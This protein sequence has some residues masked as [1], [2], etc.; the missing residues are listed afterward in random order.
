MIAR[1]LILRV[2]RAQTGIN[3]AT[4]V[5]VN[6]YNKPMFASSLSR[7][8]FNKHER[9]NDAR[10]G[11]KIKLRMPRRPP[12]LPKI[13]LRMLRPTLRKK[14]AKPKIMSKKRSTMLRNMLVTKSRNRKESLIVPTIK[15][16]IR[17]LIKNRIQIVPSTR[18]RIKFMTLKKM[19]K[20][21]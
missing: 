20:I 18:Q 4:R 21:N 16:R 11:L 9:V 15:L 8:L 1:N 6:T 5:G 2:A 13:R 14:L 3:V 19:P 12:T 17:L 7:G 10:T